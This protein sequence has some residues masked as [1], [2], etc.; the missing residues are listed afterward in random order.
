M[1]VRSMA[2]S[3]D[4]LL[5]ASYGF[6]FSQNLRKIRQSRGV[7][8]QALAE[9]AGLSRT[10]VCNLER[11]ENNSGTSADPALSTVYK[12]A[13]ALE[14]PPVLLL[15]QSADMVNSVCATTS[16]RAVA[17]KIPS[18]TVGESDMRNTKFRRG[19]RTIPEQQTLRKAGSLMSEDD[20]MLETSMGEEL[21][22]FSQEY[23]AQKR[24]Q[25]TAYKTKIVN[26]MA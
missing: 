13:L 23:T 11:N 22:P 2:V 4:R 15:P 12:L 1:G 16:T 24:R 3:V 5:W 9:I 7:T 26:R 18:A 17:Q 10:Q 19:T 21:R 14:V 6:T 20:G 8:Q 25:A